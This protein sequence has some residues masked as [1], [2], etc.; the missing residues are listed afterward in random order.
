V[1]SRERGHRR[2]EVLEELNLIPVMNLFVCLVP[3]LLL[4]AAFV[5]MGAVDAEMPSRSQSQGEKTESTQNIDLIIQVDSEFVR[6]NG[7]QNSFKTKISD[8]ETTHKIDDLT[9][10]GA[11]LAIVQEQYPDIDSTLY[12]VG[13]NV[14]YDKAIQI[15]ATLRRNQGI[16]RL[17]LAT[18]VVKQ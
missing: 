8:L 16:G 12:R 9:S 4:T 10:L 2:P 11:Q 17:V 6:I 13:G 15:L 14:P 3:F 7:F 1:R 5:H 18:E